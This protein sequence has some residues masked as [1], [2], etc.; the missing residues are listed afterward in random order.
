MRNGWLLGILA[1]AVA[2]CDSDGST[3]QA[4]VARK[5]L[6]FNLKGFLDK[7]TQ[8]LKHRSPAVVKQV[9]L[10][11]GHGETTRV[12]GISWSKELQIFYQADINKSALRGAYTVDA[13]VP[14]AG[15]LQQQTYRR[16]AGVD[17][18]VE[19]LTVLSDPQGVRE[20]AATLSQNN[21]LFFSR[22]ELILRANQGLL[23][24]YRV[25]GV[26]KL[27]LFDTLRYS[28]VVQVQQ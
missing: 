23:T 5:P 24:T 25:R 1:V 19:R 12:T 14:A 3:S 18:A 27:I 16:K 26:Q 8:L 21:A 10:R 20:V 13:P 2:A 9:K 7:Q 4:A 22:K 6:Y 28:A 17:N 15:G 11:D